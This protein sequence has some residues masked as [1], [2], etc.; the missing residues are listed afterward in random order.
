MEEGKFPS[1]LEMFENG[2]EVKRLAVDS[3]MPDLDHFGEQVHLRLRRLQRRSCG[4]QQIGV[5]FDEL[6]PAL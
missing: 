3:Q 1:C 5:P 4:G 2:R 6:H